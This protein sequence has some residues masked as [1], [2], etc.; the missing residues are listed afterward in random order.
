MNPVGYLTNTAKGLEGE[1][2][3]GYNYILAANGLFLRASNPLLSATIQIAPAEVR[4]LG[5]LTERLELTHGRIPWSLME[6]VLHFLVSPGREELYLAVVWENGAY[7]RVIPTQSGGPT[8]VQYQRARHVLLDIH[9][10]GK[11]RAFF[12]G[13]DDRDEQGFQL[14]MVVGRLDHLV[15]EVALRLGGYGYFAPL[16]WSEVFDRPPPSWLKVVTARPNFTERETHVP[17]DLR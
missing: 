11:M 14:Y 12:S 1:S 7:Q 4:G 10:H 3:I 16:D 13:T 9:T 2:G 15:K 17:P 8:S 5:H 6:Y